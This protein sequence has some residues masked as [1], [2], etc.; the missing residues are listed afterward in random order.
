[1][2]PASSRSRAPEQVEGAE[3]V[4]EAE[5]AHTSDGATSNGAGAPGA[6]SSRHPSSSEP[7]APTSTRSWLGLLGLTL[8]LAAPLVVALVALGR[9][10]WFPILDL[11]MTE[12]RIRDVG[13]RNTPLIGLPGRIGVLGEEQGSHPGPLS[14]W[15]LA[16]AYRL[17]GSSAWASEVATVVLHTAAMGTALWLARRRGGWALVLGVA[18]VLATLA[19]SYGPELLTQPWN[20]YMPLLW[21][22]VLLLAVWSVVARDVVALPV[23]MVAGSICAQT[24]APYLG[25][26]AGMVGVALLGVGAAFRG[27]SKGSAERRRI[28]RWTLGSLALGALLWTAPVVDQLTVEPGNFSLLADHFGSPPEEAVGLGT[29]VEMVLL[30]LDPWR[31]V[32]EQGADAG[33][34]SEAAQAPT[35]SLLPGIVVLLLWAGSVAVAWKLR[36]QALL[37]LHLVCG[38][39]LALAVLSISR[40]FGPLWYYLMTWAWGITSLMILATG[41]TVAAFLARRREGRPDPSLR[42]AGAAALVGATVVSTVVFAVDASGVEQPADDLSETM[43]VMVPDVLEALGD[44][45]VEGRGRDERYLVLWSDAIHIGAQG[46]A[47]VNELERAGYDVGVT[48]SWGVPVARHRIREAAESTSFVRLATGVH[49]ERWRDNPDAT[50][51]AFVDLRTPAEVAEF[52]RTR[53]DV[54]EDLEQAGLTDLVTQ[55]DFNLFAA[56]IDPRVPQAAQDGM[57]KLLQLGQPTAIFVGPATLA[58]D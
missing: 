9:P 50:E 46:I 30:H 56:A 43:A 42:R 58:Q 11:A 52:E 33:S 6:T 24:H 28:V 22:F 21:W 54:I 13:T 37:R 55:V 8:L 31:L 27:T 2:P 17:F 57:T 15:L 7:P 18:A 16:P 35:G 20:P 44:D 1:M 47:L 5:V 26:V 48:E 45:G 49:V 29:G 10:R 39:G 4:D 53:A 34:L 23:A 36:H 19:R 51:I 32:T 14:F 3:E 12:L 41:W 40:V 25:L 38:A